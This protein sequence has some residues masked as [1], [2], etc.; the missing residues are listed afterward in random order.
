MIKF[1]AYLAVAAFVLA[2]QQP[3]QA[4]KQNTDTKVF[5]ISFDGMKNDTTRK[6]LKENEL[7]HL[8]KLVKKGLMAERP[9]TISPSLTAPSHA[10]IATGAGPSQTGIVSNQW[11]DSRK[12]Y[13]NKDDAFQSKIE[14]SPIW[15]EARKSG[16][17][18][19]TIAFPGA[20]PQK[21]KQGDF[22]VFYGK[23]WSASAKEHLSFKYARGWRGLPD[24]FS[25][26]KESI[27]PIQLKNEK[28]HLLH[29]LAVDTSDDRKQNYDSFYIS[30]DKE[31]DKNDSK[32]K[33]QQWGSLLLDLD[34]EEGAGFSYKIR[35][36][37]NSLNSPAAFYRT[38]V[39]SGTIKGPEGFPE[40]IKKRFKFF[41]A[42][43]DNHALEK[44][45]ITRR[46]YEEISSRFVM[47]VTDV[48]LFIKEKYN[49]DLV[50]MYAPQID[51]EQHKYLL[52]DPRQPG[53]SKEKKKQFAGYI[54]WSYQLADRVAGKT[55]EVLNKHDQLLVV[56]DHGMEPAHTTLLPNK[57]LKDAGLL[58]VNEDGEIDFS[59]TKAYAI[60]SSS[61]AHVYIN[62]APKE[63]GGTVPEEDYEEVR[64]KII[65]IFK[66]AKVKR[67]KKGAVV[68]YELSEMASV[69]KNEGFSFS[70]IK[71]RTGAAW[72]HVFGGNVHPYEQAVKTE[73]G[74]VQ[75]GNHSGDIILFGA[76]GYIMGSSMTRESL[77]ATQLGTHGGNPHREELRP[78]FIAY[79]SQFDGDTKIKN[80]STLDIAPTI[81][82]LL[83]VKKPLFITGK[84][85]DKTNTIVSR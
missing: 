8:Q 59:K 83:G 34:I 61:I 43:D 72:N 40:E 66:D 15:S 35:A 56:S 39:T 60:P 79:G 67:N 51:H 44:G 33:G 16:K 80:M 62:A 48:S 26:P 4:E 28:N 54:K 82:N 6:Y 3:V 38:A 31:I 21:G 29:I 18:T 50:M 12:D 68:S 9:S 23:T 71:E 69:I 46:E 75:A 57:V 13:H 7:P 70:V 81:Y 63:K 58:T 30:E 22:S 25:P 53:Y 64:E 77:P 24:S 85:L 76:P 14:A 47:W 73:Q 17:T 42:Q 19:A 45:W 27:L 84:P 5:L 65:R 37:N 78:V 41:P 20:N 74:P 10:A 55:M 52:T 36:E 32:A 1:I 49:P 2:L 11:H